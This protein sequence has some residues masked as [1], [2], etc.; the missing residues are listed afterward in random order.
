MKKIHGLLLS[1]ALVLSGAGLIGSFSS[2]KQVEEVKAADPDLWIGNHDMISGTTYNP[3]DEGLGSGTA[4]YHASEKVLILNNFVYNGVGKAHAFGAVEHCALWVDGFDKLTILVKGTCTF[5]HAI[6]SSTYDSCNYHGAYFRCPV[7][8]RKES[9]SSPTPTL[10]FRTSSSVNVTSVSAL[11]NYSTLNVYDI[12]LTGVAHNNTSTSTSNE[13]RSSGLFIGFDSPT[14]FINTSATFESLGSSGIST[15]IYD[16]YTDLTLSSG[17]LSAIG[18][19]SGNSKSYG[20]YKSGSATI[21][22]TNNAAKFYAVGN[23]NAS[24]AQIKNAYSGIGY[25][26]PGDTSGTTIKASS[27]AKTYSYRKIL[28]QKITYTKDEGGSCTYDGDPHIPFRIYNVFPR[29]A[30]VSY[31]VNPDGEWTTTLPTPTNVGQ[32]KYDWKIEATDYNPASGTVSFAINKAST[33]WTT[34]PVGAEG[35][36]YDATEHNLLT[37]EAVPSN[38]TVTYTLNGVPTAASDLKA[39][40]AGIYTIVAHASVDDNHEPLN[41]IELQVEI[42]AADLVNVSHKVTGTKEYNGEELTPGFSRSAATPYDAEISWLYSL[43]EDGVYTNTIPTFTDAGDHTVYWK[44]VAPNYK[45]QGGSVVF[46]ITPANL[47]DVSVTVETSEFVYDGQAKELSVQ[48][49]GTTVDET[50]VTFKYSLNEDSGYETTLPT[51]TD[52]GEYTVY[53]KAEAANHNTVTGSFDVTIEKAESSYKEEPSA[54]EGLIYTGEPLEL[55]EAGETDDGVIKYCVGD[56]EGVYSDVVPS[57][58]EP[59]TYVVWYML[60]GDSNHNNSEPKSVTVEIAENDKTVLNKAIENG[61]KL[62]DLIKDKYPEIDA[63]LATA[64]SEGKEVE[65]S[66]TALPKDITDATTKINEA[67]VTAVEKLV[68]SIGEVKNDEQSKESIEI[69]RAAYESLSDEQKILVPQKTLADLEAKEAEYKK[70]SSGLAWWA[71]LLIVVASLAVI[72]ALLYVLM[73]YV[74]HKWI[75]KDKKAMKVF[76]CG[77]KHGRARLITQKLKVTYRYDEEIFKTKEEALKH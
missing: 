31:R 72:F 16:Y 21:S 10:N 58:T 28:F 42:E 47:S 43:T 51:L 9:D 77:H 59:G 63:T 34:L 11:T 26:N 66:S 18:G 29:T 44:V 67:C 73:F 30:T 61:D 5:T 17:E 53:W 36:K 54:I 65:N 57:K 68:E 40:N 1:C 23:T 49:T 13:I 76:V 60:E 45:S 74:F 48:T 41:D 35:L 3:G 50:A 8:I 75:K 6:S 25:T 14:N 39:T 37:T 12:N 38:G 15:G 19:T 64:L 2:S 33:S 62:H 27:S 52:A 22:I 46:T 32:Y 55:V 4:T 20:V 24:E 56:K 70:V 7:D 71:V 69:A